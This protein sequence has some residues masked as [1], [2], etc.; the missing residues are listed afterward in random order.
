MENTKE[1]VLKEEIL[2]VKPNKDKKVQESG[3]LDKLRVKKVNTASAISNQEREIIKAIKE[4]KV[5][6]QKNAIRKLIV[7]SII[8]IFF[9]GV[10]LVGNYLSGSL[11]ILSDAL[12]MLSDFSGFAISMASMIISRS[13]PSQKLSFGYHRAEVVGAMLSVVLIW[14]LTAW[15]VYEAVQRCYAPE[16]NLNP[17]IMLIVAI[18]GLICNIIMGHTLHSAVFIN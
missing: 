9:M 7:V 10:E 1:V 15:L 13:K 4:K 5:K 6:G 12:H 11:A 3:D 14:G 16:I 8:C 2:N 18:I 17:V